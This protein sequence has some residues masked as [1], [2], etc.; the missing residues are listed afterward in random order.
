MGMS[1]FIPPLLMVLIFAACDSV[2]SSSTIR[3]LSNFEVN[4]R[5]TVIGQ[6]LPRE[7]AKEL[8]AKL[9]NAPAVDLKSP[10]SMHLVK[11]M[12]SEVAWIDPRFVKV[13]V[14]LPEGLRVTYKSRIPVLSLA[15]GEQYLG[16]ISLDEYMLPEGFSKAQLDKFVKVAVE[17]NTKIPAVG[18][19]V[20]SPLLQESL[21]CFPIIDQLKMLTGINFTHI[22]RQSDYGVQEDK[23]APALSFLTDDGVEVQWGRSDA[24]P[25]P[26][27]VDR[28]GNTLSLE[29]KAQRLALVLKQFP[30]L[31]G[32]GI[33]V[34]DDPIVKVFDRKGAMLKLS[35]DI[36]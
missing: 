31:G 29:R 30:Q 3:K 5:P 26:F 22:A 18:D 19:R 36:F 32:L 10:D 24:T 14:A 9:V 8:A 35:P 6:D 13:E 16:L 11:K 21:R 20:S 7:W 2:R 17:K 34:L 15:V 27:S 23:I 33:V 25:D 28:D 12:I 4:Q 1:K